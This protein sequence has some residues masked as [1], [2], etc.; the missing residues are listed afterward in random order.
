MVTAYRSSLGSVD[1]LSANAYWNFAAGVASLEHATANSS[2]KSRD[3][4]LS[5]SFL[6]SSCFA[7]ACRFTVL[8]MAV[9]V[10]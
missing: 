2:N 8:P 7:C 10:C 5:D 6:S 3:G 9:V 4:A 1:L